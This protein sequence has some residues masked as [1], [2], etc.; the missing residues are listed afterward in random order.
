[1]LNKFLCTNRD[2]SH[3]V[4]TTDPAYVDINTNY[5]V[6]LS[7]RYSEGQFVYETSG[8]VFSDGFNPWSTGEPKN[9]NGKEDC[10]G[11]TTD[12]LHFW[13]AENCNLEFSPIC[14]AFEYFSKCPPGYE[15]V[16]SVDRCYGI[17]GDTVN[18]ST[19]QV[20][21]Q[22]CKDNGGYLIEIL[23]REQETAIVNLP[24]ALLLRLKWFWMGITDALFE[25]EFIWLEARATTEN[26]SNWNYALIGGAL[27]GDPVS[28]DDDCAYIRW[29][30]V[31]W[32]NCGCDIPV[33]NYIM[34]ETNRNVE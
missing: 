16:E 30:Y 12:N 7:D 20:A 1:M 17:F 22:T 21:N 13:S 28:K 5:W 33:G 24:Q 3:L 25:G 9:F 31:D 27:G 8:E 14:D 11:A 4:L 34:C 10:V 19:F 29:I 23:N 26:Y 2:E 15:Y 32:I 18:P 6:G